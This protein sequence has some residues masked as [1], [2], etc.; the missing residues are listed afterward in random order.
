VY[1]E[2]FW[3]FDPYFAWFDHW[4]RD[5]V[6][7]FEGQQAV[8]YSPRAGLAEPESYRPDDWRQSESW[9]PPGSVAQQWRLGGDGRLT[10]YAPEGAE[11]VEGS[12]LRFTYDPR[13]PIPTV[14]GRNMLIPSGMLDQSDVRERADYGLIYRGEALAES[15]TLAGPVRATVSVESDCPDTDFVVK[16][17][18]ARPDGTAALLMDGVVRAMYRSGDG[19]ARH[20]KP[21]EVVSVTVDLGHIHHTVERGGRLEVDITSSNFPRRIRN[22][23]SGHPL[24]AA[25]GDD[26]IRVAVNA[27]HHSTAH[28]SIIHLSVVR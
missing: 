26:D 12:P 19:V 10:R 11:D 24:L 8:L 17:I 22:T 2:R 3:P 20:L 4:L 6:D 15:M 1:E 27:V 13:R 7:P 25:D 9:P 28:P 14:G 23:N 16:L 21:G 18:E 5:G